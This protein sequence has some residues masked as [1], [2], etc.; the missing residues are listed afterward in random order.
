L[1]FARKSIK[2]KS[3][4]LRAFFLSPGVQGREDGRKGMTGNDHASRAWKGDDTVEMPILPR[5][6]SAIFLRGWDSS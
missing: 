3:T 2:F 5:R 1:I 6:V 4:R